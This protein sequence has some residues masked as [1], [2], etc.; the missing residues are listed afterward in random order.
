MLIY[1]RILGTKMFVAVNFLFREKKK[2]QR[3]DGIMFFPGVA[4]KSI[5][6]LPFDAHQIAIEKRP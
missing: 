4:L 3:E 6:A 2:V 1:D 5:S